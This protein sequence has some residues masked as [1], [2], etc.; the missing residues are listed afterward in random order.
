MQNKPILLTSGSN[1]WKWY[2][3]KL[4]SDELRYYL[5]T[6]IEGFCE[7]SSI[8]SRPEIRSTQI[9]GENLPMLLGMLKSAATPGSRWICCHLITISCVS[10]LSDQ[11]K[12]WLWTSK[13]VVMFSKEQINLIVKRRPRLGGRRQII[14]VNEELQGI[15]E[16]W[17][18][19]LQI[20]GS[21]EKSSSS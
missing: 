2:L 11:M 14:Y 8:A 21:G 19:L 7:E 10:Q 16:P 1:G 20:G 6:W 4:V 5:N 18:T 17:G 15:K 3:A 12:I 13:K 9:R